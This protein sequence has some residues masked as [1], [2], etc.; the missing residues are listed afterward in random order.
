MR[1]DIIDL[2]FRWVFCGWLLT[3]GKNASS[4]VTEYDRLML[5]YRIP[6]PMGSQIL[7]AFHR[8]F[9]HKIVAWL[10]LQHSIRRLGV[11]DQVPMRLN[12]DQ[13][14]VA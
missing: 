4:C 9:V 14:L 5:I 1:T 6:Q 12:P 8:I 10:F 11:T 7:L 2:Y 3:G 13:V